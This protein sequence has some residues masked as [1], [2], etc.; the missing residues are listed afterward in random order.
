M[1]YFNYN[2]DDGKVL[3]FTTGVEAGNMA[4]QVSKDEDEVMN[5]RLNIFHDHHINP[6]RVVFVHQSH[7]DVI[8]KVATK[9]AG[10]GYDSFESGV[11][12]DALYTKEKNL[13]LAIF[14]A[15]CVPV[16]FYDP[17]IPLVGIIH[18]GYKGALKHVVSK[19]LGKVIKD[20]HL[21]PSNIQVYI[22]PYRHKESFL[23]DMKSFEEV[24][25]AYLP[26]NNDWHLDLSMAV[27][28]D[29]GFLYIPQENVH[30]LNI[31]TFTNKD[32][33]SAYKKTPVGRMSTFILLK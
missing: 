21:N 28:F 11:E 8:Q 4:Y 17:T 26:L 19:T 6:H 5:N 14:H 33:F 30:D 29:L 23:L 31:D 18:C 2:I 15:D 27:R 13:A 7:S 12:A 32:C 10:M 20:E 16:L 24:T 22:G 3:A 9:E 1:K 25:M